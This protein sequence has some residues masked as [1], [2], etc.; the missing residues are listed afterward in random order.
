MMIGANGQYSPFT[1]FIGNGRIAF[2]VV[3]HSAKGMKR[4]SDEKEGTCAYTRRTTMALCPIIPVCD[5]VSV[6]GYGT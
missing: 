5:N 1:L 6:R 3:P 4:E 2:E